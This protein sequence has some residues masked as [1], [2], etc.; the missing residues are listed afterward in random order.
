MVYKEATVHTQAL[1]LN[2]KDILFFLVSSVE[3]VEELTTDLSFE[4]ALSWVV[5]G[6]I[7]LAVV[8]GSESDSAE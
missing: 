7:E 5:V 6:R 4:L 2:E 8:E 3:E 1:F